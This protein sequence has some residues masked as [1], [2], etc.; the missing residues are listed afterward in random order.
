MISQTLTDGKINPL[1][2]RREFNLGRAR[3]NNAN[4]VLGSDGRVEQNAWCRVR[5][6]REDD[7]TTLAQLDD[8][9]RTIVILDFDA[10]ND[11]S[12]ANDTKDLGVKLEVEVVKSLCIREDITDGTTT[13]AIADLSN[14]SSKQVQVRMKLTSQGG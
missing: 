3:F 7:G 6:R 12:L 13:E 2:D 14:I 1:R 10:S 5:A 4:L 9:T 11:G 8:L